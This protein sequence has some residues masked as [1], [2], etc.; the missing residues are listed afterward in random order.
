MLY[1]FCLFPL[2]NIGLAGFTSR[3]AATLRSY[4]HHHRLNLSPARIWI[5]DFERIPALIKLNDITSV[6]EVLTINQD[7]VNVEDD[8][9]RT[10]ILYSALTGNVEMMDLLLEFGA[11]VRQLQEPGVLIFAVESREIEVVRRLLVRIPKNT[12]NLTNALNIAAVHLNS[13]WSNKLD[14]DMMEL[15]VTR[16]D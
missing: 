7:L 15:L 16:P 10:P 11:N 4:G 5:R 2:I 9:S 6:R 12:E 13:P 14:V 1:I 8:R 3:F